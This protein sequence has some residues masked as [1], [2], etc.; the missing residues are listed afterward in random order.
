MSEAIRRLAGSV[1]IVVIALQAML[2]V[3][4]CPQLAPA[5]TGVD[6]A[7]YICHSGRSDGSTAPQPAVD[8]RC[9]FNCVLCCAP[10][11]AAPIVASLATVIVVPAGRVAAPVSA[12]SPA[13][14]R[15]PTQ[16]A[17]GPPLPV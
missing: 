14:H 15:S 9:G 2:A 13:P 8:H 11:T 7:S 4:A 16:S 3:V 5:A 10:V 6:P 17:R 1:A 12:E